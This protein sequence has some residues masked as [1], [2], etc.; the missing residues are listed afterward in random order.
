MTMNKELIEAYF[1]IASN[2]LVPGKIDSYMLVGPGLSSSSVNKRTPD[3][4]A[5]VAVIDE[6]SEKSNGNMLDAEIYRIDMEEYEFFDEYVVEQ[7]A[8][9]GLL[10]EAETEKTG[11]EFLE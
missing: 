2:R 11:R 3:E 4:S 7:A 9:D 8:N 6:E 1:H 10:A 5:Q